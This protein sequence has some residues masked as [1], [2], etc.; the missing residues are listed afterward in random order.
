MKDA[1]VTTF[2]VDPYGAYEHF[3]ARKLRT[4]ES[5]DVSLDDLR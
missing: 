4:G 3:L 5:P 2:A 1:L